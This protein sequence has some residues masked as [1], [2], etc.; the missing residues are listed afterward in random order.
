MSLDEL[1]RRLGACEDALE[2]A[3][4]KNYK[5]AW[6]SCSRADRMLWAV[7]RIG[8][9]R[10]LVVRA[11]TAIVRPSLLLVPA[12]E[13]RPRRALELAEAWA[14]G[15][16]VSVVE[17]RDAYQASFAA[18]DD[19]AI[20]G[21][22]GVACAVAYAVAYAADAINAAA[23]AM[24]NDADAMANDADAINAAA[25]LSTDPAYADIVR[26][27][28][29]WS[30]VASQLSSFLVDEPLG[31]FARSDYRCPIPRWAA[32]RHARRV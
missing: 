4:G 25:Y 19:M 6:E 17:L 23:D 16:D 22:S 7:V 18:A 14:N 24:A 28:I 3:A 20:S 12:G 29:P 9:D 11:L 15:Q 32:V 30:A 26:R 27:I 1:L 31:Q 5:H 13:L 8:L 21:A 10:R 2:W